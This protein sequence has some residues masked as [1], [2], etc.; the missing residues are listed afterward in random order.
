MIKVVNISKR[1]LSLSLTNL[2]SPGEEKT[3]KDNELELDVITKINN[4]CTLGLVCKYV[5]EEPQ[6]I[7]QTDN[8]KEETQHSDEV[9]EEVVVEN[10]IVEQPVVEEQVTEEPVIQKE[11][12]KENADTE[13]VK[14]KKT[15]A[16]RTKKS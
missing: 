7:V 13:E 1:T 16:K 15:R 5:I 14:P 6:Q 2:L 9:K 4:L 3:F 11:D 12:K 8:I 10:E